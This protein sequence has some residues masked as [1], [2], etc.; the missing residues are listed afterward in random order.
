MADAPRR[1]PALEIAFWLAPLAA[2]FVFPERRLL[3]GQIFITGLFALS[4]DMILG[5]A[6]ILSLGHAAFFGTGAYIAGLLARHGWTEPLSGAAAAAVGSAAFGYAVSLLVV[7]G[8][9]LGRLMVTLGIGLVAYEIAN[10]AGSITGGVDGLSDMAPGKLF[11]AFAFGMDGKT[12][13]AYGLVV[14]FAMF[15]FARRV[16][17]SPFGLA[18]RGIR[19]NARRMPAVG[20]D[21]NRRL[22]AVFAL[23]AGMAGVAGALLAQTTQFVG[24]D[25]LGFQRSAELLIILVFG[26]AGRL[27]GALLGAT[28]FMVA[29]DTLAGMSPEYWHFWLGAVLVALV[30]VARG[31]LMGAL[32][33]LDRRLRRRLPT[34]R[35]R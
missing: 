35:A 20:V 23:S 33:A 26:G 31:G 12:A 21:V 5:Y 34:W 4:L 22:R 14:L 1:R 27:Y 15:L 19:E 8:S 18:L 32:D 7:R 2:F 16:I 13:F 30:L 29:E 9:D 6:G 11:G 17:R 10:Q 24:I 28:V 3:M 25:T